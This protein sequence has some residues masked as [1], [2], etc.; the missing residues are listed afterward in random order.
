[1]NSMKGGE[2]LKKSLYLLSSIFSIGLLFT[3]AHSAHAERV[4]GKGA[5]SEGAEMH[6]NYQFADTTINPPLAYSW[7]SWQAG[8]NLKK[9][10][11]L[12][13]YRMYYGWG[14]SLYGRND[15]TGSIS[16]SGYVIGNPFTVSWDPSYGSVTTPVEINTLS[17]YSDNL[18]FGTDNGRLAKSNGL[19]PYN[20]PSQ[21][22]VWLTPYLGNGVVNA[23]G[24]I[25]YSGREAVLTD[26]AVNMVN[27]NNMTK[28]WQYVVPS[29]QHTSAVTTLYGDSFLA[30]TNAGTNST[31]YGY[32]FL[33]DADSNGSPEYT[34]TF[35]SG[36]PKAP[37]Y[38]TDGSELIYT[39]DALGRFYIHQAWNGATYT[40]YGYAGDMW[41]R[42]Y[43]SVGGVLLH[44]NYAY[45]STQSSSSGSQGTITRFDKK[46]TTSK[47]WYKHYCAITTTPAYVNGLI[48]FGD[49]NGDVWALDPNSMQLVNWYEDENTP[50]PVQSH[51]VGGAVRYI[52][53]ANNHLHV[54]TD[55]A[56]W[57]FKGRPDYGV[58][59]H[60]NG[61]NVNGQRFNFTNNQLPQITLENAIGNYG[62]FD[63]NVY[64]D[65]NG[66]AEQHTD[67]SL[68]NQDSGQWM[69]INEGNVWTNAPSNYA[70]SP[71]DI[72]IPK[73]GWY[74]T[75][76]NFTPPEEGRYQFNTTADAWNQQ[77]EFDKYSNNAT[78]HFDVVDM[79]KPNAQSDK[80]TYKPNET[81]TF[82]LSKSQ[83]YSYKSFNLE[84]KNP[85]GTYALALWNQTAFPNSYQFSN[86]TQRGKYTYILSINNRYGDVIY[87]DWKTFDVVNQPPV[88][89][90]TWNPSTIYN[91]TLVS[92]IDKS[93]DPDGDPLT[94]QWAYQTP[95]SNSWVNFSTNVNPTKTLNI[96]G[97]WNIKLTV[98]DT[99]GESG[100]V[101][102]TVTV[103]NRKPNVQLTYSPSNPYE[104]DLSNICVKA[105]DQDNQLLS[106]KLFVSINNGTEQTV[107]NQSNLPSGSQQCYSNTLQPG[108]YDVRTEV[109]DGIETT[110][111]STWFFAQAL[112]LKGA[113]KHTSEWDT[114]H[115]SLGHAANQFYSGEKF[116]LGAT[117]SPYPIEYV[118]STLHA[119]QADDQPIVRTVTMAAS[120]S[121]LYTGE[122]Y[123]ALFA[124]YPTNI[125]IGPATFEFE[126]KYTNGVIKTDAVVIDII[127][128]VYDAYLF[129]Q[130]Y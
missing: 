9:G 111:A 1:M 56:L 19:D 45:V 49:V 124:Q 64:G 129:H 53:G 55:N 90:F 32:G 96:I 75:F 121:T 59:Q 35:Y 102:K 13:N 42:G 94:Y 127:N 58:L 77:A 47:T 48:Y 72:Q 5:N 118:K 83:K 46:S 44:G 10:F 70:K 26:G 27:I 17:D 109:S 40:T 123:D 114:K 38:A 11:A 51:N 73:G 68:R 7:S 29:G 25:D 103:L 16:D 119:V 66:V 67:F 110:Q 37:A 128:D 8:A 105:T 80:T 21:V 69:P 39:V 74:S 76:Y 115:Q 23:I 113:V 71:R 6:R 89:D 20:S 3:S 122:L 100:S 86:L 120:S 33:W 88:A 14:N 15:Q 36:V 125:K 87:A 78:S 52:M 106:V 12:T 24:S 28:V 101:V 43:S 85:D 95:G 117:T 31:S 41:D 84:I 65:F 82:T 63:Y 18:F 112:I 30:V 2:Q 34:L 57:S 61:N 54:S 4:I 130:S 98:T 50:S 81:V 116:L 104:G 62:T 22:G 79:T 60:Y 97:N 108:R 92:F 126:V 91:D 93:R 107:I 99:S